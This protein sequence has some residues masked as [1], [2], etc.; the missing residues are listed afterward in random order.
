LRRGTLGKRRLLGLTDVVYVKGLSVQRDLE[1]EE[2]G[3]SEE[4]RGKGKEASRQAG[5]KEGRKDRVR[6]DV[7]LSA[8]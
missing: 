5:R 1:D 8:L 4:Q 2:V 3:E 7:R 6:S